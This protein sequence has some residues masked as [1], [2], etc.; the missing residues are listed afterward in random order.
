MKP[1]HQ[2]PEARLATAGVAPLSWP[3]AEGSRAMTRAG[4]QRS[5]VGVTDDSVKSA[6]TSR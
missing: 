4:R 2:A 3:P 6:A 1:M 5:D